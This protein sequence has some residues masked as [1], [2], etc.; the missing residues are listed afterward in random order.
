MQFWSDKNIKAGGWEK[1]IRAAME[2]AVAAE[3]CVLTV[4][5][6]FGDKSRDSRQI[7]RQN[8]KTLLLIFSLGRSHPRSPAHA[9]TTW[10]FSV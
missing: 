9:G 2:G 8:D 6:S 4:C 10:R 1:E 5:L 3:N 7:E